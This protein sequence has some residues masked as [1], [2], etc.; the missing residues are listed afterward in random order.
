VAEEVRKLAQRSATAAGE[1]K[2]L[3]AA[4]S[5][6][7]AEGRKLVQQAGTTIADMVA[8]VRR[9]TGMMSD[10]SAASAAQSAGIEQVNVTVTSMDD[11]T[12]QNAVLVE[13]AAAASKAM[14]QQADRLAQA[15][16]TFK[17]AA[18][19]AATGRSVPG[20]QGHR[21]ALV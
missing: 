10:I 5:D 14:Q 3:I 7:A 17:L 8:T 13:Q 12:Q 6:A 4:S 18:P 16:A 15:V 1:I 20:P 9:V 2:T 11:L 21:R 19:A